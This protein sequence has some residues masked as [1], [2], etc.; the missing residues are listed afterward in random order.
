MS[1]AFSPQ[2]DMS[3]NRLS[4]GF[5]RTL[6]ALKQPKNILE[7]GMFFGYATLC[8][9]EGAP[10]AAVTCLEWDGRY[11]EL[12][13]DSFDAHPCTNTITIVQGDATQTMLEQMQQQQFDFIFIDADKQSYTFYVEHA[14]AHLPIGG[15]LVVDNSL[16]GGRVIDTNAH[17]DIH[18]HAI[19][20]V[21]TMLLNHPNMINTLIPIRD[22]VHVAIKI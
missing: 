6:T 7:V 16:W 10:Q 2:A 18:T 8:M 17:N 13:K 19:D 5:L 12:A 3:S 4:G 11:V 1:Q 21:N 22:G 20:S 15:V 9:C 14:I